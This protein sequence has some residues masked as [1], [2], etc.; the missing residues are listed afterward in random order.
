MSGFR[1]HLMSR[2]GGHKEGTVAGQH[3]SQVKRILQSPLCE[4]RLEGLLDTIR[5]STEWIN[6]ERAV[7]GKKKKDGTLASYCFSVA[8]F[9][10]YL[11]T[12]K[13]YGA[14]S[15]V[16]R[17]SALLK[18]EQDW[19]RIGSSPKRDGKSRQV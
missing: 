18:K 16:H 3:V 4:G 13:M 10:K 17:T 11:A 9:F 7:K 15:K 8:N 5:A 12:A 2:I 1:N 19:K 6:Y 14:F